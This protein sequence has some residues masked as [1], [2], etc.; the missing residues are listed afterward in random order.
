MI[1][2]LVLLLFSVLF[3]PSCCHYTAYTLVFTFQ[4]KQRR[5]A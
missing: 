1:L 2:L 5:T 3:F 4:Y